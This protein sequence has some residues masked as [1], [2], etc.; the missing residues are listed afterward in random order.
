[1]SES[2]ATQSGER[3]TGE[4]DASLE[5]AKVLQEQEQAWLYLLQSSQN[6]S[7]AS[8]SIGDES[9]GT[10]ETGSSVQT[11]QCVSSSRLKHHVLLAAQLTTVT[12]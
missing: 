11:Q 7:T 1:M 8:A 5:L 10:R 9:L 12:T 6:P 2:I 3:V 4:A